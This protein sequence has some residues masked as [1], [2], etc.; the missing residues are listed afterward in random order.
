[1]RKIH[2]MLITMALVGL[3][4]VTGCTSNKSNN[5]TN[6]QNNTNNNH[7]NNT[8]NQTANIREILNRA[9]K[10][11]SMTYLLN[12]TTNSTLMTAQVWQKN[13]GF[14]KMQMTFMGYT[15]YIIKR[16]NETFIWNNATQTWINST[17]TT[18]TP[19]TS[20]DLLNYNLTVVGPDTFDGK[21]CTI[22]SYSNTVSGQTVNTRVWIWNDMGIP[23]KVTS[24]SAGQQ[25]TMTMSK[26]D[27][28]ALPDSTFDLTPPPHKGPTL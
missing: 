11:T 7:N 6:N 14:M 2:L 10:T 28:S 21:P 23:I 17:S 9:N 25:M 5:N 27:F 8:N 12:I 22:V 24:S 13:P 4:L 1:M 16:H 15:T 3:L 26:F 20:S 18:S 19:P